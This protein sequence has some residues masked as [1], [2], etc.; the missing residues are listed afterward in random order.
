[1]GKGELKRMTNQEKIDQ[2]I[3]L[4]EE[5]GDTKGS[6]HQRWV[7]DQLLRILLQENYRDWCIGNQ[8]TDHGIAP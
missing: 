5:Y 3:E 7:L 4:V 1:M 2:A 8:W 6:S